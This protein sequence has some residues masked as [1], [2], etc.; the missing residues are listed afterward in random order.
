MEENLKLEFEKRKLKDP[1]LLRYG[2]RKDSLKVM[3]AEM[4]KSL[5]KGI[6]GFMDPSAS[7]AGANYYLCGSAENGTA[8]KVAGDTQKC[9]GD[10]V[11]RM[12]ITGD[13]GA[14]TYIPSGGPPGLKCMKVGDSK[15]S[16]SSAT[17]GG[18]ANTGGNRVSA[19]TPD[20]TEA[21]AAATLEN[22]CTNLRSLVEEDSK[23]T[24]TVKTGAAAILPKVDTL[25]AARI[26]LYGGKSGIF[27]GNKNT[28]TDK[29]TKIPTYEGTSVA[30][31]VKDGIEELDGK[32]TNGGVLKDMLDAVGTE[33][34]H[35]KFATDVEKAKT[36]FE[37]GEKLRVKIDGEIKD[38]KAA[39][40]KIT[41][42]ETA[43]MTRLR[44]A[45]EKALTNLQER[46]GEKGDKSDKVLIDGLLGLT[47]DKGL[48]LVSNKGGTLEKVTE[49]NKK[50]KD[51][52]KG[53]KG[54]EIADLKD[55]KATLPEGTGTDASAKW[56]QAA[57]AV[58]GKVTAAEGP[59]ADLA[60]ASDENKE[61]ALPAAK[62]PVQDARKLQIDMISGIRGGVQALRNPPAA[63]NPTVAAAN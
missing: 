5:T 28:C 53:V 38:M 34:S 25:L 46:A 24:S 55:V 29:D 62:T 6:I 7:G 42:T 18:L 3:A 61:A 45:A 1:E 23:P 14:P 13:T 60:K 47:G 59:I 50:Y 22:Y 2:I 26:A 17:E 56:S 32:T 54:A 35:S 9:D 8:I 30:E 57:D 48:M 52:S 33:K 63:A 27:S 41:G 10:K 31:F 4:T 16:P 49:T 19:G 12:C 15:T 36:A 20:S 51:A 58:N 11:S 43:D 21:A 40:L 39:D 44:E 37:N